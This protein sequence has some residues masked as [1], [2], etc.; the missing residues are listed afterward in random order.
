MDCA[1]L[2]HLIHLGGP[3]FLGP[4]RQG[5]FDA[6][7]MNGPLEPLGHALDQRTDTGGSSGRHAWIASITAGVN[8]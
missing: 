1:P 5:T 2:I 4:A 7:R 6:A 8:L 3:P